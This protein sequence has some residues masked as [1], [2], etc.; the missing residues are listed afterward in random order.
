[1]TSERRRASLSRCRS[2]EPL[3]R[4]SRC[5]PGSLRCDAHCSLACRMTHEVAHTAEGVRASSLHPDCDEKPDIRWLC[6]C[7]T[8]QVRR[9]MWRAHGREQCACR[10]GGD[11]H[12]IRYAPRSCC[13]LHS[14]ASTQPCL[15]PSRPARA[16]AGAPADQTAT[17]VPRTGRTA[18]A[19]LR[20]RGCLAPHALRARALLSECRPTTHGAA[21]K[22]SPASPVTGYKLL[23]RE[24]RPL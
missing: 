13:G 11:R 3:R 19:G 10:A 4:G 2:L 8:K 17:R 22:L 16:A 23:S 7:V 15:T 9:D 21:P 24:V 20:P 12:P 5:A 18:A 6:C 1:L 14:A